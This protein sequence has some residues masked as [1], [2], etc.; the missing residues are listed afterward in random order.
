[1]P[2]GP[3]QTRDGVPGEPVADDDERGRAHR[4]GYLEGRRAGELHAAELAARLREVEHSEALRLGELMLDVLRRRR[5][6]QAR[7]LLGELVS[8]WQARRF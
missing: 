4:L 8:C 6:P 2:T 7:A 1:M 3:T 5:W